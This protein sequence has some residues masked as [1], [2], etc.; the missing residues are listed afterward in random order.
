MKATLTSKSQLT[1]P[2]EVRRRMNLGPGDQLEFRVHD[3]GWMEVHPVRRSRRPL[4][5]LRGLLGPPP[6][7]KSLSLEDIEAVIAEAAAGGGA[8]A[9]DPG[10]DESGRNDGAP[11]G[12]R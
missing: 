3:Q 6:N 4:M 9:G 8:P 11:A 5:E 2:A 7:G 10:G 1:L 12:R